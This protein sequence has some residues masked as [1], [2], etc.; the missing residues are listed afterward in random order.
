MARHAGPVRQLNRISFK[1]PLK[2]AARKI[3]TAPTFNTIKTIDFDKKNEYV[4][5]IKFIESSNRELL[6]V[7]I[8]SPDAL[9][10][11]IKGSTQDSEEK[12][13]GPLQKFVRNLLGFSLLDWIRKKI[14]GWVGN[15]WKNSKLRK[16]ILKNT[17]PL[18]KKITKIKINW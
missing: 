8:P 2:K 15:W 1:S 13:M 18:R 5:F 7:E 17:Y 4:K 16:W 11:D 14:G 3:V 9:K 10:E 6:K 12:G